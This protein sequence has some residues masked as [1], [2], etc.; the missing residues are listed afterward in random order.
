MEVPYNVDSE[1]PCAGGAHHFRLEGSFSLLKQEFPRFR[2][3]RYDTRGYHQDSIGNAKE[4][5][6]TL[7]CAD[8]ANLMSMLRIPR[9]HSVIGVGLGGATALAFAS[10]YPDRLDRFVA[11]DF[12]IASNERMQLEWDSGILYAESGNVLGNKAV[13][14]WLTADSRGSPQWE[15]VR[16]MIAAASLDGFVARRRRCIHM[17]KRKGW[18]ASMFLV[19]S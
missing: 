19:F 2:F 14:I 17:M 3:L 4:I 15:R 18:E 11:C 16:E 8:V 6:L 9:A 12:N 5:D 10:R 13:A 1:V 7:L